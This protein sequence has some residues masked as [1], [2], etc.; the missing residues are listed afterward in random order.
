MKP[1]TLYFAGSHYPF[2]LRNRLVSY[3]YPEQINTWF[4]MTGDMPGKIIVDSGAFSAWQTGKVI[5]IGKY[6]EYAHDVIERGK[7]L[8]KVVRVVNL[9]VIPGSVGKSK[10]LNKLVGE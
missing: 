9:D 10:A 3:A 5:D 6:I 1:I 7:A 8:N 4:K 2:P